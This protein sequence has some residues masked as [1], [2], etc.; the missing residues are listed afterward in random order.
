VHLSIVVVM[1][2]FTSDFN[3]DFGSLGGVP[4]PGKNNTYRQIQ[5][6]VADEFGDRQDLLRRS[7]SAFVAGRKILLP[8]KAI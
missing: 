7:V 2:G 5:Q 8:N 4:G 3:S 6:Q 1:S